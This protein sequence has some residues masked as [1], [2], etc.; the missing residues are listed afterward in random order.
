MF[1]AFNTCL[2]FREY[3]DAIEFEFD[4]L[5]IFQNCY[6]YNQPEHDVVTMAKK[7]EDVFKNKMSRMPKETPQPPPAAKSSGQGGGAAARLQQAKEAEAVDSDDTSSDWNKR[8][9]QVRL[10]L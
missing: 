10:T 3:T 8:L 5:S 1:M 2:V 6:K 4:V 9:L 7:L